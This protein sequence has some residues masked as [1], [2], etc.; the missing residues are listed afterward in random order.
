MPFRVDIAPSALADA[1][2]A[3][4]W[5]RER[6]HSEAT[7]WYNGLLEAIFSLE[8]FPTRCRL[9]AESEDLGIEIRQL[10]YGKGGTVY[11]ILFTIPGEDVVRVFHIRHTARDRLRP[12][13]V[14]GAHG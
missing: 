7:D 12:E 8:S 11:R 3:Y 5:M 10:L 6:S 2:E 1:G 14:E 9:A 4:L 13:D